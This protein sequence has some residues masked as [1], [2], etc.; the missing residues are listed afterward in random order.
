ME[1]GEASTVYYCEDSITSQGCEKLR[2]VYGA[3]CSGRGLDGTCN[4]WRD[5]KTRAER[6]VVIVGSGPGGIG[7]AFGAFDRGFDTLVLERGRRPS[8]LKREL[9]RRSATTPS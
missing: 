3:C 6:D 5:E 1:I 2:G 4:A 7:A 8:A 9:D